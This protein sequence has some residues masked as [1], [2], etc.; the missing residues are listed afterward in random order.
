MYVCVRAC[1]QVS[2]AVQY[3]KN[4]YIHT[5]QRANDVVEEANDLLSHAQ[6]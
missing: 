6:V 2:V 3:V 4:G 1:V 5:K